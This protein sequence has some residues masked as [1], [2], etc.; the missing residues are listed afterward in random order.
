MELTLSQTAL[1]GAVGHADASLYGGAQRAGR[2]GRS[3]QSSS[4]RLP[5]RGRHQHCPTLQNA[6]KAVVVSSRF[7]P[8]GTAARSASSR[9]R[10][11]TSRCRRSAAT[12]SP[13]RW[14]WATR[15]TARTSSGRR[16]S[17]RS[18]TPS[19]NAPSR[20]PLGFAVVLQDDDAA[21]EH[22]FKRSSRG[23]RSTRRGGRSSRS[24]RP[25]RCAWPTSCAA[26]RPSWS[27]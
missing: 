20:R 9:S 24:S 6:S 4:W 7:V 27:A 10:S 16:A 2:A 14:A 5:S 13:T 23:S 1:D 21:S 12:R 18:A 3:S 11:G 17:S 15:T 22:R 25:S 8:A 26:C 19:G